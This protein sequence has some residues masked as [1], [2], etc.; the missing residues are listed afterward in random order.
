MW[1]LIFLISV[2]EA[3]K[4]DKL[5]SRQDCQRLIVTN[6]SHDSIEYKAGVDSSGNPVVQP[7]LP[8][9]KTYNLGEK[10]TIPL[11]LPLKSFAPNYPTDGNPYVDAT[12]DKSKIYTGIVDIDKDGT[13]KIN[14]EKVED[15]E[16][17]KIRSECKKKFPDLN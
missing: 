3:K 4:T 16:Q 10:V 12:I 15:E 14:G 2:A 9:S 17:E 6:K 8:G 11:E 1:F 7:N 13:I 5:L